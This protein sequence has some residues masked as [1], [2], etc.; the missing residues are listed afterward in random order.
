MFHENILYISYRKYI[1]RNFWLVICI[2]KNFICLFNL[3]IK[4]IYSAFRWSRNL[5]LE[6][7]TR[8][9]GFVV[10]G[11]IC[12]PLCEIQAKVSKSNYEITSIKFDFFH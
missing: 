3:I 12:D 8:K 6:K 11:H 2:P 1:K 4:L 7:L 10:Q 5:N 9:T